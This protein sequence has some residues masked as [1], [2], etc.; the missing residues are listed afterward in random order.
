MAR[1]VYFRSKVKQRA[2]EQLRKTRAKIDADNPELLESVRRQIS[3]PPEIKKNC[4]SR[5][6]IDRKKSLETVKTLMEI[7]QK[8]P[9]FQEELKKIL[10]ET[11]L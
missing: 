3:S 9:S 2:F 10:L 1:R 8:S 11:K 5:Y 7:T 6:K 4:G